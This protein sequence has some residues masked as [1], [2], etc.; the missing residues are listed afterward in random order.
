[1]T[2][3]RRPAAAR[4]GIRRPHLPEDAGRRS[5]SVQRSRDLPLPPLERR[6]AA[7]VLTGLTA[8][9][10]GFAA[11]GVLVTLHQGG[12]PAYWCLVSLGLLGVGALGFSSPRTPADAARPPIWS[13]AGLASVAEPLGLS[14]VLV[15]GAF[16]AL[17]VIGLLGNVV[18]PL[19][20]RP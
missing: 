18:L 12:S 14:R 3:P 1:V 7:G 20:Q 16:Y 10:L 15:A 13:R 5:P 9:G 19:L 8:F 17:V 4:T 2:R 6:Q 11:A